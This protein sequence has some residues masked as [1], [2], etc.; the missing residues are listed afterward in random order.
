MGQS[1]RPLA[2]RVQNVRGGR[3]AAP[4]PQHAAW[5]RVCSRGTHS[6]A[7]LGA[8]GRA[9]QRLLEGTPGCTQ[10]PPCPRWLTRWSAR[11]PP[12]LQQRQGA[13]HQPSAVHARHRAGQLHGMLPCRV[14]R[15]RPAAAQPARP[16]LSCAPGCRCRCWCWRRGR[17]RAPARLACCHC[18]AQAWASGHHPEWRPRC[19]QAQHTGGRR[20]CRRGGA[21]AVHLS[22]TLAPQSAA[23]GRALSRC[24]WRRIARAPRNEML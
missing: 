12:T 15:P 11:W 3:H 4:C 17:G 22:A 5:R 18:P 24:A 19:T 14:Q 2:A 7:W 20:A 9:H 8:A 13:P 16:H 1:S 10:R 23:C 21:A 6:M